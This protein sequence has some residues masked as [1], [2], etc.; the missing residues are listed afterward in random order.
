MQLC[1]LDS[2]LGDFKRESQLCKSDRSQLPAEFYACTLVP[3]ILEKL[4]SISLCA[5]YEFIRHCGL[6]LAYIKE[7]DRLRKPTFTYLCQIDHLQGDPP[8]SLSTIFP[9][10]L[11]EDSTISSSNKCIICPSPESSEMATDDNQD[12]RRLVLG[13]E[14]TAIQRILTKQSG[15]IPCFGAKL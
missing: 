8:R 15:I 3:R 11:K 10:E 9:D 2:S 7:M 5:W 4:W 13:K 14:N 12:I 6:A 1:Q